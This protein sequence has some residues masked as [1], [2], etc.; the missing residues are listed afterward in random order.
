M[1]RVR[2][3][4]KEL[5]LNWKFTYLALFT[6]TIIFILCFTVITFIFSRREIRDTKALLT[7]DYH[8]A[9]DLLDTFMNEHF[10][11]SYTVVCSKWAQQLLSK[12]MFSSEADYQLYKANA[13]H[14]LNS[15]S[16]IS[17]DM[18]CVIFSKDN[19]FVK[20]NNSFKLKNGYSI[21][22][23]AWY[24][25]L[26]KDHKYIDYSGGG[27]F[28]NNTV[29]RSISVYYLVNSIYNFKLLGYYAV[30]LGYN[31][32]DFLREAASVDEYIIIKDE[33]G[34]YVLSNFD[35]TDDISGILNQEMV[36]K[37]IKKDGYIVYKNTLMNDHWNVWIFKKNRPLFDTFSKYIY[38]FLI[39][40]PVVTILLIIS[41]L[42]L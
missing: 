11:T 22:H 35:N 37:V 28:T 40:P 19:K 30:N 14:F 9:E 16:T 38:A 6:F 1:K 24:G 18:N 39:L 12:T 41:L 4:R 42:F 34:N 7:A 5:N 33:Y 2:N 15:I 10:M 25:K 31:Q 29:K 13:T 17:N 23:E 36:D 3:N 20:N 32:F 21:T 27:L 8:R 26:L